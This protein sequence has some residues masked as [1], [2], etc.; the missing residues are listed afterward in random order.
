VQVLS[1]KWHQNPSN[2][3]S[4]VHHDVTDRQTDRPCYGEMWEM[5][6]SRRNR[7]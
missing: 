7:I 2:G 3:L 5:C 4:N 6:H 1:V